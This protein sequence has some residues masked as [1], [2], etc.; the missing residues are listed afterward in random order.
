M[1]WRREEQQGSRSV[2]NEEALRHAAAAAE[3]SIEFGGMPGAHVALLFSILDNF[4]NS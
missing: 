2:V 4:L 3:G 1:F